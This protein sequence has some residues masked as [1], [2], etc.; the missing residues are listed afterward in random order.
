MQ[1]NK[2]II[3]TRKNQTSSI[4]LFLNHQNV[5]KGIFRFMNLKSPVRPMDI[6]RQSYEHPA[7]GP[8]RMLGRLLGRPW[9][10]APV[11]RPEPEAAKL[12]RG[13]TDLLRSKQILLTK[14]SCL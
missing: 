10:E 5:Y 11:E 2:F 7:A 4:D 6:R 8:S 9:A 14:Y 12:A 13:H 3:H 1:L